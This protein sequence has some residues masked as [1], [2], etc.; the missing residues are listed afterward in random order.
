VSRQTSRRSR[1]STTRWIA[2]AATATAVALLTVYAYVGN[3]FKPG[4]ELSAI[5]SSSNQLHPG[6]AV[7]LGGLRVGEVEGISPTKDHTKSILRFRI[8]DKNLPV[9]ADAAIAIRPRLFLEG[10]FYVDLRPG[11]PSAA[12]IRAGAQLSEA[13]TSRPVQ[14]DQ[15]VSVLTATTRSA[16][17]GT[18]HELAKGLGGPAGGADA[19]GRSMR[20]LDAALGDTT[21]TVASFRGTDPDDVRQLVSGAAGVTRQL[22]ERRDAVSGVLRGAAQVTRALGRHD[23]DIAA[24]IT[25]LDR[26]EA[27]A[28][29]SLS[30]ISR[31]LPAIRALATAAR[32]TLKALPQRSRQ[33]IA[34]LRPLH[35]LAG[36]SEL[37]AVVNSVHA[38]LPVVP[39]LSRGLRGALPF[40]DEAT[41]CTLTHVLPV[42][43]QRVPDGT[44]T[45]DQPVWL[46]GL[47][48]ATSLT[49]YTPGFDANGTTLRLGVAAGTTLFDGLI[50]GL[51]ASVVLGPNVI[52]V[53]PDLSQLPGEPPYRPDQRCADQQLPKLASDTAPPMLGAKLHRAGLAPGALAQGKLMRLLERVLHPTGANRGSK[54]GGSSSPAQR[55]KP[56]SPVPSIKTQKPEP[57]TAPVP[58]LPDTLT[59]LLKGLLGGD[60]QPPPDGGKG[61]AGLLDYLLGP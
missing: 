15:I 26:L 7:K 25:E 3:P 22:S 1:R 24:T 12:R 42:M 9:F 27:S 59:G 43:D 16:L 6:A 31:G 35:A 13:Q 56:Q 19:L 61:V 37:P 17:R 44:L 38:L 49:G 39:Q 58:K 48:L 11:T 52:G 2:G 30:R 28:P 41:R 23:D 53:R 14:L 20:E 45:V 18:V 8:T 60:K 40:L 10:S 47:H 4:Y 51:G 5:V 34:A 33:L 46:E 36:R 29:G 57:P 21:R 54:K 50:P 32:P 55:P